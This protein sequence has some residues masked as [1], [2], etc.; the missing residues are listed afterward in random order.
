MRKVVDDQITYISRLHDP[1][2]LL[3]V[4]KFNQD[5]ISAVKYEEC[6]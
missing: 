3:N 4:Q 1:E 5:N 2:N 6:K